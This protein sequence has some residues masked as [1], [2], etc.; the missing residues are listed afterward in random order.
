ML[1]AM[2][3]AGLALL[4]SGR[5]GSAGAMFALAT[6][7]K[8]Y[9]VAVLP[10]LL[11]RR[12]WRAAAAMTIC[13]AFFLL[14]APAPFRGFE[15]NL[16]EVKTWSEG[17]ISSANQDGFGQRSELSWSW[18]NNSLLAVTH[19]LLRPLNAEAMDPLAKPIYVNVLDLSYRQANLV[20]LA[21]A[22]LIGAGFCAVLPP[23][24]R[25]SLRS[26]ATEFAL[27]LS[28]MTVASPLARSYYF[29]WLLFPIT[30]LAYRAA[31][32][33]SAKARLV[34]WSLLALAAILGAAPFLGGGHWS[35]A[36]GNLLWATGVIVGA[37][38]WH[39]R[40]SL[41]PDSSPGE[42]SASAP[43]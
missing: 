37:L 5:E 18:K 10:Y 8:A 34:T 23:E 39:L 17:M 12:R 4:Q 20:L 14:I 3:L 2:M 19:R 30:V 35:Q 41:A 33:P 28:L 21:V 16:Q 40:R 9:P 13:A 36:A 11:W 24:R 29:I 22:C 1:L 15:R 31:L 7:L 26:D 38:V 42:L 32:E 27:L 6:A 25:R 43:P